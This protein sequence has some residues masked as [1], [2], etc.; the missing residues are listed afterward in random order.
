MTNTIINALEWRASI[1][2]F[3]PEKKLSETQL[4]TLLTSLHLSASSFG[5]QPWKFL[6]ITNPELRQ[7]LRENSWNQTQVTDA[8][9]LIVLCRKTD[10]TPSDVDTYIQHIATT[11][12][13]PAEAL[14]GYAQMMKGYIANMDESQRASWMEKQVY[15]ALGSLLTAAAVE[16]IDSCPLEGFDKNAYNTLLDLPRLGYSAC[17][18]CALGFRD[19]TDTYG[20]AKKVRFP[21]ETVITHIS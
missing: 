18:V 14:A 6:V 16:K 4:N 10:I 12:N 5:L 1:K 3:N 20:S 7:K 21:K 11:R 8:S 17:V 13:T 9:H 15:I 2:V 19:A